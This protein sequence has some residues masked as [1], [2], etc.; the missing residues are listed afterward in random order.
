LAS[1]D[2]DAVFSLAAAAIVVA[3]TAAAIAAAIAEN[4]AVVVA[5]AAEQDQQDDDPAP[6]TATE[7]VIAHIKYLH[8]KFFEGTY[9]AH[10]K[11]FQ[12]AKNVQQ[13]KFPFVD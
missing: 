9:A 12:P 13:R 6:V 8:M 5:T 1:P 11:I 10:S 3:A 4:A 7:T 2:G